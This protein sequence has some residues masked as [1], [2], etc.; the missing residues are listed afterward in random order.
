VLWLCA[1]AVAVAVAVVVAVLWLCSP[2]RHLRYHAANFSFRQTSS[3]PRP[4]V[5]TPGGLR[6]RG[7]APK[8]D[9]EQLGGWARELMS[10]GGV[11]GGGAGRTSAPTGEQISLFKAESQ[12]RS[13]AAEVQRA[14]TK[15]MEVSKLQGDLMTE[16]IK[17]SGQLD[18]IE[19]DAA[20]ADINIAKG[21]A[22]IKT[23]MAASND[24]RWGVVFFLLMC[25][26]S[27][28]YIELTQ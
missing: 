21:N 19:Q 2:V 10:G 20:E 7:G 17:Q 6:R 1:V 27:L 22:E 25:A 14:E 12:Q 24:L 15:V 4:A 28:M 8:R 16:L 9:A 11:G 23:A 3:S 18:D 26:F 13:L 5:P